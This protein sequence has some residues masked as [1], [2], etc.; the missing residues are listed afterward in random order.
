VHNSV[1]S[2]ISSTYCRIDGGGGAKPDVPATVGTEA[3]EVGLFW[4]LRNLVP[5]RDIN[6]LMDGKYAPLVS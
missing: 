3:G 6:R 1:I 5:D 4:Q 2:G